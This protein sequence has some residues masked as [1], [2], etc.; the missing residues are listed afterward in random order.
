MGRKTSNKMRLYHR[1]L[2]F[3][4]AGIMAVYAISGITLIFRDTDTFKKEVVVEKTLEANLSAAE[5]GKQLKIKK[6]K[7]TNETNAVIEFKNGS[8]NKQSG[9]A[10]Y[11]KLEV[12]YVLNKLQHFHKAETG[13]PLYFLNIFFGVSLLFFVVS[14]FW[15]FMP[16]TPIFKK[17][18]LFAAAGLVLALVLLFV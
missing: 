7:T 2:G 8:Y 12:P 6:F 10:S 15:M 14:A 11:I 9:A 18:L 4:L 3:F 1:Y 5:V 13:D 16:S 17:G